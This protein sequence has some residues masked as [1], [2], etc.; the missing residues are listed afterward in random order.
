MVLLDFVDRWL[1]SP[2]PSTLLPDFHGW[3]GDPG[4]PVNMENEEDA[5]PMAYVFCQE[6]VQTKGR[7]IYY[8]IYMFSGSAR[9]R[10]YINLI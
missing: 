5:V 8:P 1:V 2:I 7:I 9:K 6:N 10:R 4:T 3:N